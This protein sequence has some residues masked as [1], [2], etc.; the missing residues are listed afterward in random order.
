MYSSE[1][2]FTEQI[3]SEI[4]KASPFCKTIER[5]TKTVVLNEVSLGYG[6]ADIVV[7]HAE[8]P[9]KRTKNELNQTDLFVYNCVT[10][11]PG[12]NI[13]WLSSA[14]KISDRTLKGTIDK[15]LQACLIA[16]RTDSYYSHKDY[17]FCFSES[18]AIEVKL[19]N[20]RRALR[21]AYRYKWFSEKSFVCLP[22]NKST[23]AKHNMVMFQRLAVGLMTIS[24]T[25]Q[26]TTVFDPPAEKP[27]N[28]VMKMMLN[29]ELLTRLHDF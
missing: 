25:G 17:E 15:L 20:W 26:L 14:T 28:A 23:Q 11:W 13:K 27:I 7:A 4:H 6:V 12:Q 19:N 3:V 9:A 10:T 8:R 16:Q 29:E 24:D 5:N 2:A 1:V 18:F 22:D 21:Q